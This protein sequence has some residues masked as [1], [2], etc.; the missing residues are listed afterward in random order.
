MI[1]DRYPR[2]RTKP[3]PRAQLAPIAPAP[4]HDHRED[5]KV[6]CPMCRI[7]ITAEQRIELLRVHEL[8]HIQEE[9][10]GPRD[11]EEGS[12]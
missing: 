5:T 9:L 2:R 11:D 7:P 12:R 8:V 1:D 3:F 4:V 6:E 10:I